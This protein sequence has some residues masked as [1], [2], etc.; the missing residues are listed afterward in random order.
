MDRNF[1]INIIIVDSVTSVEVSSSAEDDDAI[2]SLNAKIK[3]VKN[4]IVQ[5]QQ[6]KEL[7]EEEQTQDEEE[8]RKKKEESQD[9]REALFVMRKRRGEV[10]Q[11]A[12][13]QLRQIQ[14][15]KVNLVIYFEHKSLKIQIAFEK[16]LFFPSLEENVE[17][18]DLHQVRQL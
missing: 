3:D 11:Q 5:L 4:Q 15:N 12:Y 8:L 7:V 6:N 18:N 17:N 16:E 1:S 13:E 14:A 10:R 2:S 9:V